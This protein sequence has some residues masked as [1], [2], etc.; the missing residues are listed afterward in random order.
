MTTAG[1]RLSGLAARIGSLPWHPVAFAAA[2]VLNAYVATGL[3]PQTAVRALVVVIAAATGLT[4]LAWLVARNPQRGGI[5]AT[6]VVAA[7]VLSRE[8][9]GILGRAIDALAAWQAL[10]LSVFLAAAVALG[11]RLAWS[12]L[13]QQGGRSRWTSGLNLLASVLIGLI[14]VDGVLQGVLVADDMRQGAPLASHED[15]HLVPRSGPDIYLVLLD[16]YPRAD[17]LARRFGYDNSA[18]LAALEQRGFEVA[19]GSHSNYTRTLLT[20]TSLFHISLLTDIDDLRAVLAETVPV[21]PTARRVLNHNPVIAMLR[22]LGYV[23]ISGAPPYEDAALRQTDLFWEV[24]YL[25]DLEYQLLASTFVLDAIHFLLPTELADERRGQIEQPLQ[26]MVEVAEDRTLGPR[27]DFVHVLAPHTPFVYG[28]DGEPLK[29]TRFRTTTNTA[30]AYGLTREQYTALLAGQVTYL[31]ARVLRA[32]DD[33][34]RAS[35]EPP[36]IILFADHGPRRRVLTAETASREDLREAFAT[37]FAAYTPG[38]SEV[39]PAD[40]TPARLMTYLL[41]AYF[42]TDLPLAGDGAFLSPGAKQFPL[43]EVPDPP[44]PE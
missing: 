10:M 22:S 39:F 17:T 19:A 35:E 31:N 36:I 15:R 20:L 23:T 34:L 21:Q 42:G 25:N 1:G 26:R 38:H 16:G 28:A 4:L 27:F 6:F 14:I 9:A 30:E 41:N 3:V 32:V 11:L 8:L 37:L 44:G 7:V 18:F 33:V 13:R 5:A 43:V 24:P 12:S 2:Y 29:L 40:V